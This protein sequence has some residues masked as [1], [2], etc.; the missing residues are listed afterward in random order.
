[1][2]TNRVEVLAVLFKGTVSQYFLSPF[3][4][5]ANGSI[6][7]SDPPPKLETS[8]CSNMVNRKSYDAVFFA[9]ILLFFFTPKMPKMQKLNLPHTVENKI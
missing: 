9:V 2:H 1:M 4:G 3:L 7:H 8:L 5:C 6:M